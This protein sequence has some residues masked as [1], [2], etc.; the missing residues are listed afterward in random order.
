ME[1]IAAKTGL[2]VEEDDPAHP[3]RRRTGARAS[4]GRLSDIGRRSSRIVLCTHGEVIGDV[5]A[6]LAPEDGVRLRRRPPG[7]KG[8]AW[9]LDF[10]QG[11]VA[12]ARYISPG[13]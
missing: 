7:L 11:K 12:T 2:V 3:Q 1:P 13:R 8:C 9:V 4:S 6:V 10:H 5:L